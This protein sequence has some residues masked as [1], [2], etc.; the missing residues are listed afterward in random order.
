MTAFSDRSVRYI[1]LGERAFIAV[2]LKAREA[3][4]SL[5]ECLAMN[6]T[7]FSSVFLAS[8]LHLTAPALGL[9]PVS[10][11]CVGQGESGLLLFGPPRSGKT[12]SAYWAGKLGLDF[13]SDKATFLEVHEGAVRAWGGFWPAAFR[14][15][16]ARFLPE[17][18]TLRSSFSHLDR[19][20]FVHRQKPVAP[21]R[22]SMGETG[23]LHLS[24]E[25]GCGETQTDSNFQ[26]GSG[27]AG[28]DRCRLKGRRRRGMQAT[29]G[30]AIV[31]SPLW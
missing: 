12:V 29:P 11:A 30:A 26:S 17:L 20:Y 6:K 1:D 28:S 18:S 22:F 23:S 27:G 7:G 25:G 31:S 19:T 8:L 14:E 5:P 21:G 9:I 24:G 3:V 15:D 4:G 16:T 10:A 2:D 13:H